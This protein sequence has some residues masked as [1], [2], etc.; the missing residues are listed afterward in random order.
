M[1][2]R[3]T[4]RPSRETGPDPRAASRSDPGSAAGPDDE[5][6][7]VGIFP[8]WRSLYVAVILYTAALVAILYLLTRLLDYSAA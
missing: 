8:S 1:R 4:S 6:G 2:R 3:P 7:R 5:D